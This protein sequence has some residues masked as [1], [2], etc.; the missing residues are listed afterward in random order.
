[1][2]GTVGPGFTIKLMLGA[3]G[4]KLKKGVRYRFASTT[5]RRSDF[6]LMGRD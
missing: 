3:E 1:V 2:Q 5:S 4:L 6:H